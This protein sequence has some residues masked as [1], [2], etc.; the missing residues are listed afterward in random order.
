M[1]LNITQEQFIEMYK[2]MKNEDIE[3]EL[4]VSAYHIRKYG[5]MLGLVKKRGR[6]VEIYGFKKEE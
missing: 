4:G 1:E 3:K 2:T 5:E 6:H